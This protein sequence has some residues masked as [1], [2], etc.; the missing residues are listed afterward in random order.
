M[1]KRISSPFSQALYAVE[2]LTDR[3][4]NLGRLDERQNVEERNQEDSYRLLSWRNSIHEPHRDVINNEEVQ[5]REE[6]DVDGHSELPPPYDTDLSL[7][8]TSPTSPT[9][10][11]NPIKHSR[12]FH[13]DL[14]LI[15]IILLGI[16]IGG[17]LFIIFPFPTTIPAFL[18]LLTILVG[19]VTITWL[20]TIYYSLVS[21]QIIREKSDTLHHRHPSTS[22][23]S[24]KLYFNKFGT[25]KRTILLSSTFFLLYLAYLGLIVP[26]EE[27]PRLNTNGNEKYF[28][29]ANL[30]DSQD[31]LPSWST[32]LVKLIDHL[33]NDNVFVSI[34]E[35]NSH[36]ST[37]TLLS[38]LNQTLFDKGVGRR[39]ITAQDDKHWWPYSTSPERIGY[40]ASARNKALEPI[41][42]TDP[43]I[44]LDG[45]AG[46]TKVIFLNDVYFTWKSL[47]RLIATKVEGQDEYDQVCALDF[48]A[49]GLYDTWAS[50]D[51]CGTPLRPF[52][53]YIKDPV[54]IEKLEE[55]EPFEVSSCWNGAVVFKSGPFLYKPPTEEM[56]EPEN[57]ALEGEYQM[58]KRGWKMVDNPTYP[59]SVF[60]PTLTLPIQFRTSNISACDH[61]ECFL[62]GYDLHR[63]YDSVER[64]PRIYMNPTVKLAYEKKWF[65]WHNKVLRVPVIQWWLENWSRGYPF[66]F[67][68]WIWEK[69]GRRRDY[70]TWSALSP[71]LPDRCPPLP[72]A[73]AKHWDE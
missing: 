3:I 67:V 28:I 63:L 6:D 52:W 35:S 60:S 13:L 24:S 31:I 16:G 30:H 68:D 22:S 45:Y 51:I 7:S 37:K 23:C 56:I 58:I 70:C 19:W 21:Y 42:S 2:V 12:R 15:T 54:T 64:P 25:T 43:S 1:D 34:Y 32:E 59:N 46:F 65:V 27:L 26:Q 11:N 50:R 17:V 20:R 36:D 53:P 69:A 49:S 71:H 39:I 44:R 57:P 41:Q 9:S 66:Y 18:C 4:K 8:P 48:G 72:G 73:Q 61:S 47:V 40:L 33:G 5:E 10:L 62:I 38:S 14:L 55:E 29:A